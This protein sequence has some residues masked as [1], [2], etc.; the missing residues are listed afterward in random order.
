MT[1][2]YKLE[3]STNTRIQSLEPLLALCF[4][5]KTPLTD[6]YTKPRARTRTCIKSW[7]QHQYL[8]LKPKNNTN[9]STFKAQNQHWHPASST[10][11][12]L[13]TAF[14]PENNT[15]TSIQSPEIAPTHLHSNPNINLTT[16]FK[17]RTWQASIK[18]LFGTCIGL[19]N[20]RWQLW[21]LNFIWV[22]FYL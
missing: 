15:N 14:K 5:P 6:T 19:S 12:A 10:E 1:L 7:K 3:T 17:T 11:P 18:S 9:T 16:S 13:A 22:Y 21:I 20:K 8:H 2:Y 4:K